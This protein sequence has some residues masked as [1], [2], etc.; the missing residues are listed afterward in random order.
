[1]SAMRTLLACATLW[2]MMQNAPAKQIINTGPAPV[3]PYSPAVAAGG[4][5]YVSGTLAQDASGA[6]VGKGDIA[7]QTRR[8]MERMQDV[9]KAAGTSLDRV[10]AVTVYLK[11]AADF[12][13]MNDVYRT[14][15]PK[16]PPTRTTV[17][18]DFVVPDAMVEISMIAVPPGAERAVVHPGGWIQSP[19]PYSYA[20]RSGDTLFLSGLVARNGRDNSVVA[21]DITTQTRAVMQNAREILEAAGMT[22]ANVVS[23]RVFLTDAANF[24]AMNEIYR[25]SFPTA[26]PA[27]ATVKA[28]LAGS[29]YL[30]EMT[31]VASS[32]ARQQVGQASANLPLSA[33]IKAGQRVYLSGVLGNT[34]Q[35][36]G[37]TAAQTREVLARV[38]KTLDAAGAAPADVVDA[39]VYLKNAG[40]FQAMNGEYRTFF[41]KEFPARATVVTPLVADDGLVE[42]MFTAAVR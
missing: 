8:V 23:T 1:M 35:T 32:S 11:S 24:Q 10:V 3:G 2:I 21:G 22:F 27:R 19:N 18:V 9:L 14:Y 37:D 13:A 6:I 5:I 16:E 33:A 25:G 7:A 28:A 42:I 4:F 41:G 17:V 29:Q 26:P 30:V 31:M 20:I 34:P 39:L 40:D 12:Q 15:W 38:R 36:K